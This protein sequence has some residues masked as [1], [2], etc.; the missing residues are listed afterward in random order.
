MSNESV[1]SKYSDQRVLIKVC[2]MDS[3]ECTTCPVNR[4]ESKRVGLVRVRGPSGQHAD[5]CADL[6]GQNDVVSGVYKK[7]LFIFFS[8]FSSSFF[9]PSLI[10]LESFSLQQVAENRSAASA[11]VRRSGRCC[12]RHTPVAFPVKK[13][14]NQ[15]I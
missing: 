7:P 1:W 15:Q 10:K 9:T 3:C 12:R 14:T 11:A 13:G 8:A 4:E 5:P 6:F 2:K